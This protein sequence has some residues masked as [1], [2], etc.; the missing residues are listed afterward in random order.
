MKQTP[1]IIGLLTLLWGI[2]THGQTVEP[3]T[4]NQVPSAAQALSAWQD[5]RLDPLTRLDRTQPFLAFIRDSGQVHVVLNN[6]LLAWMYQPMDD[7]LKATLYAAFLG[8][9]MAA[10]LDTKRRGDDDDGDVAGMAAALDAY[11]QLRKVHPAFTL[12][13]FEHLAKARS[14]L[15]LAQAV[16][17]IKAANESLLGEPA[18]HGD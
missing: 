4:A 3:V 18:Y 1:C 11:A 2:A 8:G 10:Q 13:V 16:Q 6:N 17:G 7:A 15:Q 9:N 12:P 5:F 14:A